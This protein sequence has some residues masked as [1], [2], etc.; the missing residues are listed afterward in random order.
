MASWHESLF[1][2]PNPVNEK[3]ART[4]AAGVVVMSVA[5]LAL[6][7][8]W[9]LVPLA[10][11]FYARLLTGPTLSPLGQLATRVVA[12]RLLGRP[13]LVAGPPKRFA[14][15]IG[16]VVTT[17]ALLTWVSAGWDPAR[18]LLG[19]LA[20]AALAESAAGYCLGCKIFALLMRAGL[21]PESVC[22]DCA[23]VR[24][25]HPTLARPTPG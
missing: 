9:M 17:A 20:A 13:R 8:P 11:G 10:L 15:G 4:V 3:A 12:P 7:L 16:A 23:D 1:S 19:L 22:E 5:A 25:R 6:N 14:Q 2:F 24:R 18:W 21:V